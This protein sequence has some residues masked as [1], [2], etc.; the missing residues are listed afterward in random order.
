[1][2]NIISIILRIF[3]MSQAI[4]LRARGGLFYGDAEPEELADKLLA[5]ILKDPRKQGK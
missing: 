4:K 1:M 3:C 5:Y 2:R